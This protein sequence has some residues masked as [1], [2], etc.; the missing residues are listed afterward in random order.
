MAYLQSLAVLTTTLLSSPG[1]L[2]KAVAVVRNAYEENLT[3][4]SAFGTIH[5]HATDG[6]L[7]QASSVEE[8]PGLIKSDWK[9]RSPSQGLF[10]F[11]GQKRRYENLYPTEELVARR[12]KRSN[13][14]WSSP[15][16]AIRLLLDGETTLVDN[17]NVA[18]DDKTVVHTPG[19]YKGIR[20]FIARQHIPLRL[21]DPEPSR[22]T[23]AGCL[24]DFVDGGKG[25]TLASVDESARLDDIGV[26]KLSF[27]L[28]NPRHASHVLGRSRA[29]SDPAS[30][31]DGRRSPG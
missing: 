9:R 13:T 10:V 18:R 6:E 28:P 8:I 4:L 15:I 14:S 22:T 26:V 5:F 16:S 7:G 24:R 27:E 17:V 19:C 2:P 23:L 1:E 30:N 11:D 12:V 25:V 31:A 21:T 29:W 20:W 3:A